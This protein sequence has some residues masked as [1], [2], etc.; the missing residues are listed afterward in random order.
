MDSAE[1]LTSS[2]CDESKCVSQGG[3]N[4][5]SNDTRQSF[6]NSF[7]CYGD[8]GT[9]Y[10]KMCADGFVPIAVDDEPT[11]S[12][13]DWYGREDANISVS[14]FTCCPPSLATDDDDTF[15]ATRR[16]S[17]PTIV[18]F[19]DKIFSKDTIC[20]K[21][22]SFPYLRRMKTNDLRLIKFG[23]LAK[24]SESSD[25]IDSYLCCN[26]ATNSTTNDFLESTECVPYRNDIYNG[27]FPENRMG[28]V[29][30]TIPPRT[31]DFPDN[32][33]S[34]PR[35]SVISS[36]YQCCK[37]G[38]PLPLYVEDSIFN[39]SVYS[40]TALFGISA[41]LSLIVVLGLWIPLIK[42]RKR[43]FVMSSRARQGSSFSNYNVYLIYLAFLDLVWCTY[44][45]IARVL[46]IHQVY[47]PNADSIWMTIGIAYYAGNFWINAIILYDIFLLLKC[48]KNAQRRRPP[49]LKRSN[50]QGLGVYTFVVVYGVVVGLY[51]IPNEALLSFYVVNSLVTGP[52][53]M[54]VSA[55]PFWIWWH[56][57]LPPLSSGTTPSTGTSK[58]ANSA[59]VQVVGRDALR[60]P[61]PRDKALRDLTIY[62]FRVVLSS[63]QC[64]CLSVYSCSW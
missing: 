2:V 19:D 43:K 53:L 36:R 45:V 24:F 3:W 27:F 61:N 38:T 17:D 41:V 30:E 18:A 31:C 39:I 49:S 15:K 60:H 6:R 51:F 46:Y 26:Y 54:F 8:E 12:S 48:S 7:T 22:S 42:S 14:Y 58:I 56:G 55:L 9:F 63:W 1:V 23:P 11:L 13:A 59:M 16:C 28:S 44:G 32:S 29:F 34:V 64:T 50:L 25:G 21:E 4:H 52:P 20:Q 40:S 10:P 57:Y 47:L 35:P 5:F 33:Y 62:F 37:T